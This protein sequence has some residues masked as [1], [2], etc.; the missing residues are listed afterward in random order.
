MYGTFAWK[1]VNIVKFILPTNML[2]S[3]NTHTE[4]SMQLLFHWQSC[5]C[6]HGCLD[7]FSLFFHNVLSGIYYEKQTWKVDKLRSSILIS[8]TDMCSLCVVL[9]DRAYCSFHSW[10]FENVVAHLLG[11]N[12]QHHWAKKPDVLRWKSI[13]NVLL[14]MPKQLW[15]TSSKMLLGYFC[16]WFS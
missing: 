5:F 2:T 16:S 8:F 3:K 7:W 1:Y 11:Q 4:G 9:L 14:W 13:R 10:E 12:K 15:V 6:F